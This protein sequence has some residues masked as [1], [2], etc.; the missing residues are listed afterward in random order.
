M[1]KTIAIFTPS[2]NRPHRL[3]ELVENIRQTTTVPFKLY[4][5][6]SDEES[7]NILDSLGVSFWV[8]EGGTWI[9]RNNFM[10]EKTDEPYIFLGSDD[11]RYHPNWDIEALK[12]ME[13]VDGVVPVNDKHN[14]NGTSALISR[15]YIDT[16]SGC[17]D[18]K[19]VI[20]Y[21]EYQH[22][23]ADTELFETAKSRERFRYAINSVVEHL[24][25][26]AK[27]APIDD[28]YKKSDKT[29]LKDKKLYDS[30]KHLWGM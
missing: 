5:V 16:M 1:G 4:F 14:P 2:L 20:A 18:A 9:E 8:D 19:G 23:Y 3:K 30:R 13:E 26:A 22:N 11:L 28:T 29:I 6:V 10:Y 27:K 12:V 15:N 17:I 25:H 24:H 21:P 7:V